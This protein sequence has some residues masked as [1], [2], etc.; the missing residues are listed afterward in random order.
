MCGGNKK[1]KKN[2]KKKM[3]AFCDEKKKKG[4]LVGGLITP[5]SD[6]YHCISVT[7]KYDTKPACMKYEV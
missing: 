5:F 4:W 6:V 3:N 1:M 7:R 2:E